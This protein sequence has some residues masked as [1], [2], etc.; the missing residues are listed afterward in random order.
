MTDS[1]VKGLKALK[2]SLSEDL[3]QPN[4]RSQEEH[5]V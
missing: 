3:F 2:N 4:A 1:L 5:S